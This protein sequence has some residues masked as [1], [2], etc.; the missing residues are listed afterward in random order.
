MLDL[1]V[2][3]PNLFV[4]FLTYSPCQPIHALFPSNRCFVWVRN[5]KRNTNY[6]SMTEDYLLSEN[7][8]K[9]NTPIHAQNLGS[10]SPQF[11]LEA[12]PHEISTRPFRHLKLQYL[13]PHPSR[14]LSA[15]IHPKHRIHNNGCVSHR[16][17]GWL[18]ELRQ[19]RF[20]TLHAL[21]A[22]STHDIQCKTLR[23]RQ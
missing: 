14:I 18:M 7:G 11:R 17:R 22:T 16:P 23:P 13:S 4:F 5:T 15:G 9:K 3:R 6:S 12:Q 1:N 19:Q 21:I 10:C 20:L 8:E 2:M